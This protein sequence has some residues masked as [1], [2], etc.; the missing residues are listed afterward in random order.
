MRLRNDQLPAQLNKSLAP[1]YLLSG[2]E[3]LQLGEAADQVRQAARSQGFS[4]R[5]ILVI[6]LNTVSCFVET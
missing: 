6:F 3:P 2:D 1:V 5:S 4:E